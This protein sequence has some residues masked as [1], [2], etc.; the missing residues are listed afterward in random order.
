MTDVI[1]KIKEKAKDTKDLVVGSTND[2]ANV[3]KKDHSVREGEDS[4]YNSASV[5]EQYDPNTSSTSEENIR[6][7]TIDSKDT[8]NSSGIV[9]WDSIIHKGVR[10]KD[11]QPVGNVTAVTDNTIVITSEGARDEFNI[12]KEEVEAFNG[13]EVSLNTTIDRFEQFKVKVPR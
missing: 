4:R 13:A 10:T 6:D 12:P 11:M 9:D 1:D 8:S 5:T 2:V 3:S 7:T